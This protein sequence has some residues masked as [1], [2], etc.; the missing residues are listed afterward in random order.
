MYDISNF[1]LKDMTEC[2]SALRSIGTGVVTMEE[3]ADKIVRYCYDNLF[4]KKTG[5]KACVLVRLFKTH[6]FEELDTELQWFARNILGAYPE[7][8]AMKCLVLLASAGI[9]PEW[10]SRKNSIGHKAIPLPSKI[11][12]EAFPMIRQL[13]QQLGLEVNTVLNP[14]P[15]VIM[16]MVQRTYNVFNVPQAV[17]SNYIIAQEDFVIPFGVKSVIGFGGMLPSGNLFTVILF[18]K[19]PVSRETAE[20]FKTLAL[21][22]KVALLLFDD[23]TVF[24]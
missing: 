17:G 21:S 2:S 12:I 15:D 18:S 22:V 24:T 4:D 16:D 19:V 11:F 6:S 8:P 1:T 13:I 20:M 10:N 5:E 3:V 14:D 9:K 23:E 7:S